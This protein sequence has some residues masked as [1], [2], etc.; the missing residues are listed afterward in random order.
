MRTL[1]LLAVSAC[2]VA[3]CDRSPTQTAA[4]PAKPSA[5]LAAREPPTASAAPS[6]AP[7]AEARFGGGTDDADDPRLPFRI[8]RLYP[9]ETP[10]DHAP[11]HGGKGGWVFFDAETPGG[12]AFTAGIE[13]KA[14]RTDSPIGFGKAMIVAPDRARADRLVGEIAA[15]FQAS[16][17]QAAAHPRPSAPLQVPIAVLGEHLACQPGGG[18]GGSGPWTAT[19]WFF[20][21]GVIEVFVNL[22]LAD[23][24]G[25]FAEKDEAY[26]AGLVAAFATLRDG[27][28][29]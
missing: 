12:G 15:A 9:G 29:K 17:P 5:P 23:K 3:A 20:A 11:W 21:D 27:A 25:E 18:C 22:D 16:A 24:Q 7:I 4:T 2:V 28:A 8:T 13:L 14:A 19:K 26:R 10:T 6:A 1:A